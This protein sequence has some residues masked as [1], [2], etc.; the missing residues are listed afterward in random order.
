MD[1]MK[2]F[3]QGD[4]FARRLGIELVEVTEGGAKAKMPIK[5]FHFNALG[6]VQGGA[7]FS[8]ADFVFEAASNSYGTVA[9]AINVSISYLR[10]TRGGTLFADATEV[11]RNPKLAS[12]AINIKDEDGNLV[13]I[14]QGMVY[15][16]KDQI[17]LTDVEKL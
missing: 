14:F 10:A 6:S 5:D 16:K 4:L 7:I 8:L 15:R 1:K 2:K 17:V 3:F 13:A 12:Y 9:V 11:S